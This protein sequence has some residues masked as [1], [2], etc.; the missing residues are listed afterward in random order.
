MTM[1]GTFTFGM[2]AATRGDLA[3]APAYVANERSPAG[4]VAVSR[5]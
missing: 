1:P 3:I 5:R 4:T 2:A